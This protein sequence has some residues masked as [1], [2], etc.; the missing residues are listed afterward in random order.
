MQFKS[1][2]VN[3]CRSVIMVVEFYIVLCKNKK[4]VSII[5]NILNGL[6][7][8]LY[9]QGFM[10]MDFFLSQIWIFPSIAFDFDK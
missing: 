3:T 7:D 10:R 5:K 8:F 6:F 4:A 1:R 2:L 9:T